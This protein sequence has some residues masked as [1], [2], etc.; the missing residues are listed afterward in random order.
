MFIRL[1]VSGR[2][3]QDRAPERRAGDRPQQHPRN[4]A[5]CVSVDVASDLHL[6]TTIDARKGSKGHLKASTTIAADDQGSV[7]AAPPEFELPQKT[8]EHDNLDHGYC[9]DGTA[10][11]NPHILGSLLGMHRPPLAVSMA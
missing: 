9:R 8:L 6:P 7:E 3:N 2:H 1:E 5:P 11:E 4:F 10:I